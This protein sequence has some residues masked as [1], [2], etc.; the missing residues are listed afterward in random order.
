[1]PWT[2]IFPHSTLGWRS[3]EYGID[4]T[5]ID[6]LIHVVIH[7]HHM[8]DLTHTDPT[9]L[10]NTDQETARKAHLRRVGEVMAK[11]THHDPDNHLDVI[12]KA[13]DP[14]HPSLAQQRKVIQ[15]IRTRMG[16]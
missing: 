13:W 10:W 2:Y 5:D 3:A 14:T 12:R 6:T 16:R 7:E 15:D 8:F 9:F 4:P 11:V 1:M